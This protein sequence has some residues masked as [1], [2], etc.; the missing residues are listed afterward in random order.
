MEW[1]A[2]LDTEINSHDAATRLLAFPL[3]QRLNYVS[4][5]RRYLGGQ[6]LPAHD[7]R[8]RHDAHEGCHGLVPQVLRTD[9]QRVTREDSGAHSAALA[10]VT[11]DRAGIHVSDADDI[12]SDQFVFQ[13]A[14]STPVRGAASG[15]THDEAGH[16][17]AGGLRILIVDARV[18]DVWGRHD[19]NLAVVRRI[20]EGLLVASHARREHDLTERATARA[21]GMSLE[22]V[23][24][25]RT[26]R[27]ISVVVIDPPWQSG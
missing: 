6:R 19:D 12:L 26:S 8:L 4:L 25:S 27:A 11:G 5:I 15:V 21:P 13:F 23:P 2:R 10:D 1:R 20:G 7:G 24:S 9:G 18:P 17:D 22:T 16:P 3:P 14:A